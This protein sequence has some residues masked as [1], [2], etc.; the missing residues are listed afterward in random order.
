MFDF[1]QSL[2]HMADAMEQLD[3]ILSEKFIRPTNF[4]IGAFDVYAEW[5]R[6]ESTETTVDSVWLV[7]RKDGVVMNANFREGWPECGASDFDAKQASEW[8]LDLTRDWEWEFKRDGSTTSESIR[9]AP[10]YRHRENLNPS[11][12]GFN[13]R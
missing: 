7:A 5:G 1:T 13:R 11:G 4:G 6:N 2:R 12:S 10:R 8:L 9:R 3:G